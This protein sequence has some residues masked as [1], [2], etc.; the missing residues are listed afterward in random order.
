MMPAPGPTNVI[1]EEDISPWFVE[2]EHTETL[3]ARDVVP[4][5]Q[6]LIRAGNFEGAGKLL[7]IYNSPQIQRDLQDDAFFY[8]SAMELLEKDFDGAPLGPDRYHAVVQLIDLAENYNCSTTALQIIKAAS[9]LAMGLRAEAIE[10]FHKLLASHHDPERELQVMMD[11]AKRDEKTRMILYLNLRTMIRENPPKT[12][13]I[14]DT[15]LAL[16]HL[17]YKV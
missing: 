8:N 6:G 9:L 7:D 13:P 5:L 12:K 17:A 10:L 1:S 2:D 11:S 15:A 14:A 4:Q 16:R 3:Y